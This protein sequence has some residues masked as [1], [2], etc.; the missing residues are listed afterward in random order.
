MYFIDEIITHT[1]AK[2]FGVR[3]HEGDMPSEG[4][5]ITMISKAEFEDWYNQL[6]EVAWEDYQEMVED[7]TGIYMY[8]RKYLEHLLL[9]DSYCQECDELGRDCGDHIDYSD[10]LND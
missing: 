6:D 5:L 2:K 3:Y 1:D 10:Y 8:M 9:E 7:P 4:G